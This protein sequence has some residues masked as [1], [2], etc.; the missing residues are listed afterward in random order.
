MVRN[1][2]RPLPHNPRGMGTEETEK[3]PYPEVGDTK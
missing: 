3:S 1:V 2:V